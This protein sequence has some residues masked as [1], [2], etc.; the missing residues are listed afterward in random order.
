MLSNQHVIYGS[1]VADKAQRWFIG[2]SLS[3]PQYF[4]VLKGVVGSVYPRGG[5]VLAQIGRRQ[6]FHWPGYT[7]CITFYTGIES[8]SGLL[9]RN[10]LHY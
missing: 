8:G 10:Q 4:K 2:V 1:R 5:R 6:S 9:K 3:D 7:G